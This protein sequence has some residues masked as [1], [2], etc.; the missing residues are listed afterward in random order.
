MMQYKDFGF[1][2]IPP[3]SIEFVVVV[4]VLISPLG[5]LNW[6]WKLIS[7]TVGSSSKFCSV[8]LTLVGLLGV[9]CSCVCFGGE[10]EIWAV[11]M[12]QFGDASLLFS[13]L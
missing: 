2:Y 8:L 10:P 7:S 12:T 11:F 6:N 4:V 13:P 9:C 3:K 5:W 1:C